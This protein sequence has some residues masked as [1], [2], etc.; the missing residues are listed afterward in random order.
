MHDT[1]QSQTSF[2]NKTIITITAQHPSDLDA[3][4]WDILCSLVEWLNDE[5]NR[6]F[7]SK[8]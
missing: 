4:N 7:A 8:S 2:D 6:I 5:M 1:V 3:E